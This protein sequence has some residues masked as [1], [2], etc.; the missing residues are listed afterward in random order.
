MSKAVKDNSPREMHVLL[1]TVLK[2]LKHFFC[3][4]WNRIYE[5]SVFTVLSVR[6]LVSFTKQ[7]QFFIRILYS[8]S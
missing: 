1:R 6:L 8:V 5:M 4:G 3:R 2:L 7:L